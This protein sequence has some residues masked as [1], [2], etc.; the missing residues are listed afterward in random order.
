[1]TSEELLSKTIN[2][3]RFPLSIGIVF[4]HNK[5][6][7]IDIQ[8][9]SYDF[10][11]WHSVKY[12]V[13]LLSDVM[14]RIA[15]PLFFLFSGFLF[16]NKLR[17]AFSGKIYRSKIRRRV[18][19]LL[20]PYLFWNFIGFLILLV[21]LHPSF[22]SYFPKF[23]NAHI[24]IASFLGCFWN[25]NITGDPTETP[26]PIDGPMWYVRELIILC[27]FSPI[28]WWLIKTLKV[29]VLFFLG[30][31][32]FFSLGSYVNLPGMSHQAAFFFPLGAFYAINEINFVKC[33]NESRVVKYVLCIVP[34]LI[35]LD[36]T[37]FSNNTIHKT[38]IL[39]GMLAAIYVA[40]RMIRSGKVEENKFLS[41]FSFFL[42]CLHYLII[43]KFMKMLVM[44]IMPASPLV[45]LI[46]Y[47][48]VPIFV[49]LI[50][51]GIYRL[52]KKYMPSFLKTINGGR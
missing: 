44:L 6:D 36:V 18:R 25:F 32:W 40:S 7:S 43:N 31:V 10:G 17:G 38:W 46:M 3:L 24:D 22:A 27:V 21:Q 15:V 2:I 42:F 1:M 12:T 48:C 51:L 5:M 49:I 39:F 16:F 19:S 33:I 9:V 28:I 14:P 4:I 47:I 23:Q 34:V 8:G 41:N 30:V 29:V 13:R 45:V 37:F 11:V 50:C 52:M 26:C 20:I 35:I